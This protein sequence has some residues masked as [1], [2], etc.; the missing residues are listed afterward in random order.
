V[1]NVQGARQP[2]ILLQ[3]GGEGVLLR[4]GLEFLHQQRR[5]LGIAGRLLVLS[6]LSLAL[7]FGKVFFG[8]F[9]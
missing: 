5:W 1:H 6:L 9:V 8:T 2:S 4:M 3:G 7:P